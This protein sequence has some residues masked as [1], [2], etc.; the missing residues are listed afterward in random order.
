MGRPRPERVSAHVWRDSRWGFK[1]CVSDVQDA[2]NCLDVA[3]EKVRRAEAKRIFYAA[4]VGQ[5]ERE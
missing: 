2:R 3:D 1:A 5:L 4:I